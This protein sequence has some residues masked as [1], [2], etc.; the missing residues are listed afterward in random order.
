MSHGITDPTAP[1]GWQ[2][3]DAGCRQ[4]GIAAMTPAE[5]G[6]REALEAPRQSLV[7]A[8]IYLA[9]GE[10]LKAHEQIQLAHDQLIA[11]AKQARHR[12]AGGE[13]P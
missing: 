12:H 13:E 5:P 2:C 6:L 3:G 8:S 4:H 10:P 9:N 1:L 11:V 7:R